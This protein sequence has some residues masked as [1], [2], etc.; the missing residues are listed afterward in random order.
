MDHILY[1]RFRIGSSCSVLRL[2][3]CLFER[4]DGI[5]SRLSG[6]GWRRSSPGTP[7]QLMRSGGAQRGPCLCQRSNAPIL[8]AFMHRSPG[9]QPDTLSVTSRTP[10]DVMYRVTAANVLAVP[11]RRAVVRLL[12]TRAAT[13]RCFRLF[14]EIWSRSQSLKRMCAC[15][16][17][18]FCLEDPCSKHEPNV[19]RSIQTPCERRLSP[20]SLTAGWTSR[21]ST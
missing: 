9:C 19:R 16:S 7:S 12:T 8:H 14:A 3:V 17:P 15:P 1:N 18:Y 21:G 13:H 20:I 11:V 6:P 10:A 2:T 4:I 5:E